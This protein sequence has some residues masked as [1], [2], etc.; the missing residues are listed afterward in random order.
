MSN[1]V[2]NG[3]ATL[4]TGATNGAAIESEMVRPR[5]RWIQG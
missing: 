4:G 5:D 2:S 3:T 1:D